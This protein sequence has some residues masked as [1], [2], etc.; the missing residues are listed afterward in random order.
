MLKL[1]KYYTAFILPIILAVMLL[2]VQA[3]FDLKLPDYMSDIV[4]IGIQSNGISEV[5]PEAISE[6]GFELMKIFM[7]KESSELVDANYMKVNPEDPEYATKYP[8]NSEKTIYVL[9]SE[10][11]TDEEI[12]K[13]SNCFAISARTMLNV[14]T[15]MS[16]E[17]KTSEENTTQKSDID[18]NQIY[19]MLPMMRLISEDQINEARNQAIQTPE[20]MLNSIGLVFTQAFYNELQLNVNDI[21]QN[22]IIAT[23][24]KMLGI[25]VVGII[26]A[27]LVGFLGSKIGAGIGKNLRK[28][29]FEKVEGF[30]TA[31]FNKFSSASLI[32]RTTNDITQVQ[33]VLVM[34]IRM[35]AYA[36]IM[37]IGA[38]IM[39]SQKSTN[40]IWTIGLACILIIVIIALLFK[41]V[42]PKIKIVQKLTDKINLVA[43]ES[44]SGLMVV[45]AFGT[46]SYEE[47]RFDEINT[48]VMKTNKFVNRSMS[49]MMPTMML[50]MNLLNVLILWCGAD[51]I[52]QSTMQV[53]DLMAVMQYGIEVVMSFL[54]VSMIFVMLPRASVSANRIA[55][56]LEMPNSINDPENA[57]EFI[58]DKMG[59]VE[60]KNVTFKYPDAEEKILEN[61]SFTAKPGQTTAII[62]ATG[63]GKSTIVS[64]IPRLFDVTEGEILV[65]GVNVKDVKQEELHNQIGYIP[66]KGNLLSGTIES[67]LK[68][69][70]E[71]A[72][73]EEVEECAKIAQAVEFIESKEEKYNSPISQGA[74]NVSGGQKQRLSIARALV[75]NSPIYI[76]DDSFS[77]LDFK[78]D[79]NLRKA[80]KE[81]SKQSTLIIVAQRVSTIMN[82]EQIIVLDEGKIVGIG[83]HEELLKNCPTYLEIASSQLSEEELKKGGNE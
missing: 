16:G 6:D 10:N 55:E 9:L 53:G 68:Y 36:P 47:N 58:K 26:A 44:L 80:L 34:M 60:F 59:Y 5:A 78:T 43:K 50:I 7:D 30:S 33:N 75:K 81:H 37:G 45:R 61:I 3:M 21:G 54:F 1:K 27:V 73:K 39:M 49:M 12:D 8:A 83:T 70:N 65:N 13:I 41:I 57:K 77:A 56:V 22:Y 18:L 38:L 72:T 31:E 64:L 67:N 11:L 82:A 23:G 48:K 2:F 19:E 14:M 25:C 24:L 28:D 17:E 51:A 46:Q 63:S 79:S 20:S 76:F 71:N 52:S 4:N 42:L 29:V 66:Q 32:T 69:G 40:L 62:G 74:K 35:L 15:N